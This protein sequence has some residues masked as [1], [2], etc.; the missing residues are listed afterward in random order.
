MAVRF[1]DSNLTYSNII[2]LP[3]PSDKK[4]YPIRWII[5]ALFATAAFVMSLLIIFLIE[6]NNQKS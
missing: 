4:S 3:Y 1:T 2:S 5:V 6:N